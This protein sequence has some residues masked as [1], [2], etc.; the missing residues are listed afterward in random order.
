MPYTNPLDIPEAMR[1]ALYCHEVLRKAG[2]PS[3]DIFVSKVRDGIMVVVKRGADEYPVAGYLCD[4]AESEFEERWP[5]AVKFWNET[6][7]TD[8][9]WGFKDSATR[10]NAVMILAPLAIVGIVG[11]GD[12]N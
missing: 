12:M 5:E 8:K 6:C 10:M 11:R 3:D 4:I 7:A 9:R 2:V 1:E